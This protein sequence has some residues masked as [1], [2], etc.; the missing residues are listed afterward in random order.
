MAK[1]RACASAFAK[2]QGLDVEDAAVAEAINN[3][4]YAKI[5]ELSMAEEQ[6]D[7]EAE[8]AAPTITLASFVEME[9]SDDKYGGLLGRRNK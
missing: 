9:V 8:P 3:L 6:D 5:A 1:K 4:D 2:K 7:A